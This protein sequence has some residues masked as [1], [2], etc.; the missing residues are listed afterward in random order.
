[1]K[2]NEEQYRLW[3]KAMQ[4][5]R[6]MGEVEQDQTAPVGFLDKLIAA[7]LSLSAY[8]HRATQSFLNGEPPPTSLMS[9]YNDVLQNVAQYGFWGKFGAAVSSLASLPLGVAQPAISALGAIYNR[10]SSSFVTGISSFGTLV[11]EQIEKL[12]AYL[13][14]R[15]G[16]ISEEQYQLRVKSAESAASDMIQQ[17]KQQQ[18]TRI[19]SGMGLLGQVLL[20]WDMNM[21]GNWFSRRVVYQDER[22]QIHEET[23]NA[24]ELDKRLREL[25]NS[26]NSIIKFQVEPTDAEKRAT[27]AAN[28][29]DIADPV[30]NFV[31]GGAFKLLQPVN[32]FLFSSVAK[33]VSNNSLTRYVSSV[34]GSTIAEKIGRLEAKVGMGLTGTSRA[35]ATMFAP[36]NR[37][38]NAKIEMV[39]RISDGLE[40][41]FMEGRG[42]VA[43]MLENNPDNL[44]RLLGDDAVDLLTSLRDDF[45]QSYENKIAGGMTEA[46]AVSAVRDEIRKT[47]ATALFVHTG[48]PLQQ[49]VLDAVRKASGGADVD[50]VYNAIKEYGVTETNAEALATLI[51]TGLLSDVDF[52]VELSPQRLGSAA[53]TMIRLL[54]T[55]NSERVE[56]AQRIL[57]DP[58]LSLSTERLAKRYGVAVN[59]NVLDFVDREFVFLKK[60]KR[61]RLA[62][63]LSLLDTTDPLER[64]AVS[65]VVMFNLLSELSGA[66]QLQRQVLNRLLVRTLDKEAT[67]PIA[68][69]AQTLRQTGLGFEAAVRNPETLRRL[70]DTWNDEAVQRE[71]TGLVEL[72]NIIQELKDMG[73]GE[74]VLTALSCFGDVSYPIAITLDSVLKQPQEFWAQLIHTSGGASAY[75]TEHALRTNIVREL[76]QRGVDIDTLPSDTVRRWLNGDVSYFQPVLPPNERLAAQTIYGILD[77]LGLDTT[78]F[79]K[80]HDLIDQ[81]K[82]VVGRVVHE[83]LEG[84]APEELNKIFSSYQD[85]QSLL[86]TIE[87]RL[88]DNGYVED[89]NR[90]YYFR[91][92]GH[93][94]DRTLT[95]LFGGHIADLSPNAHRLIQ[96]YLN[97]FAVLYYGGKE[98]AIREGRDILIRSMLGLDSKLEPSL[99]FFSDHPT[100]LHTRRIDDIS[101][102]EG[103]YTTPFIYQ[104]LRGIVDEQ[105]VWKGWLDF[106]NT[107]LKMSSVVWQPMAVLRDFVS[108]TFAIQHGMGWRPDEAYK[109]GLYYYKA[110][111]AIRNRSQTFLDMAEQTPS[112]WGATV[113][114]AEIG[115]EL[116]EKQQSGFLTHRVLWKLSALPLFRHLQAIRGY[117]ESM[118]KMAMYFAVE[119]LLKNAQRSPETLQRLA[120]EFDIPPTLL[121]QDANHFATL[122]AEK[123]MIDY[124][125]VPPAVRFL[126]NYIGIFPFITYEYKML[127]NLLGNIIHGSRYDSF[128][129]IL[130][131]IQKSQRMVDLIQG[132]NPDEEYQQMSE[133]LRQLLP[134]RLKSDPFVFTWY[135]KDTHRV[136]T[137]SL[138]Y[139]LPYGVLLPIQRVLNNPTDVDVWMSEAKQRLGGLL[140]PL[141]EVLFNRNLFTGKPIYNPEA[142]PTEKMQTILKYLLQEAAPLLPPSLKEAIL[143]P[144]DEEELNKAYSVGAQE[145]PIAKF[146]G[147]YMIDVDRYAE[148]A[149][150]KKQQQ[151]NR[152]LRTAIKEYQSAIKQGK[153]QEAKERIAFYLR[154]ANKIRME[155]EAA[156]DTVYKL[157]GF[158][159]D[160]RYWKNP[161]VGFDPQ[162]DYTFEIEMMQ[163][164][165]DHLFETNQI[166]QETTKE[167]ILEHIVRSAEFLVRLLLTGQYIQDEDS[168]VADNEMAAFRQ[169]I[170]NRANAQRN[171]ADSETVPPP[172]FP[173]FPEITPQ[174]LE[175]LLYGYHTYPQHQLPP[176]AYNT[177]PTATDETPRVATPRVVNENLEGLMKRQQVVPSIGGE[178]T[179]LKGRGEEV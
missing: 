178:P 165:I 7:P 114:T 52:S 150:K 32:R 14:Y 6:N 19:R 154:N 105:R 135:D 118:G 20:H 87:N 146:F 139:Y 103:K 21:G 22:G 133:A 3:L 62:V 92:Q 129:Y 68:D 174:R 179:Q 164:Y 149:L 91:Q 132:S 136:K 41:F 126:R 8:V 107:I 156:M 163:H 9:T 177:V 54:L 93:D 95:A 34:Y 28:V 130:N 86:T 23:V 85:T 170:K 17:L 75:T 30:F 98:Y 152:L 145:D 26:G 172:L 42:I 169:R 99:S 147:I 36:F 65:D 73:Y 39:K 167:Q 77:E 61:N 55:K 119:D 74:L 38:Y 18:Q 46:E 15:S 35:F 64:Q 72:K 29:L 31:G 106:I 102:I 153:P 44:K 37:K 57:R 63:A 110:Y 122:V 82:A 89:A 162:R 96:E 127:S 69:V 25:Q 94:I 158:R 166:P 142:P 83:H 80:A 101:G 58:T 131:A 1:M 90:V 128:F 47:F 123:Y 76:V 84:T 2:L 40:Q 104:V 171:A 143:F 134:Q 159:G 13:Q 11:G 117:S 45:R 121:S 78:L 100:L 115:R 59:Q 49:D 56:L 111:E 24:Y 124:H 10:V 16:E 144:K 97:P 120:K 155:T 51:H 137:I 140:V 88:L 160:V 50:A 67:A 33:V 151:M 43:D 66:E 60:S 27:I 4:Q 81:Y 79:A 109:L 168:V 112:V 71:A 12:D 157:S 116:M 53:D 148:N 161:S 108:N 176:D 48:L 5:G 113:H 173:V 125:D 138:S 70:I 175:R 141:S